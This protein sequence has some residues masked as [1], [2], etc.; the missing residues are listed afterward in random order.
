VFILIKTIKD[1]RP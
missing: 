1:H